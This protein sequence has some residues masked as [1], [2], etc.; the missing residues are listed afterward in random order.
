MLP[1]GKLFWAGILVFQI[2]YGVVI[3]LAT[4][5]YFENEPESSTMP[6]APV[7]GLGDWQSAAMQ[8]ALSSLTTNEAMPDDPATIS[9]LADQ[10]YANQEYTKAAEY[11]E[12]LLGFDPGNA[13]I[14]NNL[15]LTLHYSGQSTES[16]AVLA[17]NVAAHPEHQRSWLT[18]G[19]VN[20]QLGDAPA[21]RRALE[22][23]ISIDPASDV[24]Q[25][26][27][28]MLDGL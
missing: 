8:E 1:K 2:V 26:A 4:R 20:G 13:D 23:A 15:G 25:S 27:Q 7:A 16:L 28:S 10:H 18:L 3:F 14:R 11:Y 24:G 5:A 9:F 6:T 22:M 19:F 21:S 12:R 17:E